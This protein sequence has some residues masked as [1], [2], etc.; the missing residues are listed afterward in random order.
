VYKIRDQAFLGG[1]VGPL[2]NPLEHDVRVEDRGQ[3]AD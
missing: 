3:L 2:H 1:A